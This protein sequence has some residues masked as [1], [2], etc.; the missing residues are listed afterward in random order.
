MRTPAHFHIVQHVAEGQFQVL[1]QCSQIFALQLPAQFFVQAVDRRRR[2]SLRAG[3][4]SAAP[5]KADRLC[6]CN[7][8]GI[9]SARR[10]PPRGRG[11]RR[12]RAKDGGT[13]FC[14][15]RGRGLPPPQTPPS[16]RR[17]GGL[18]PLRR[19]D[20]LSRAR[21][22]RR[23]RYKNAGS[24]ATRRLPSRRGRLLP[25]GNRSPC[26]SAAPQRAAR[27]PQPRPPS[28]AKISNFAKEVN[29][30][31]KNWRLTSSE[32]GKGQ[33][34]PVSS[35]ISMGHRGRWRRAYTK[36][37]PTASPPL[38]AFY[39]RKRNS[40]QGGHIRRQGFQSA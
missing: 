36:G 28:A 11:R 19:A 3:R 16:K 40:R 4:R 35:P 29:S 8:R 12:I 1:I 6:R 33:H 14:R 34:P 39:I 26:R 10:L 22:I 25:P 30:S 20:L 5:R 7:R 21:R 32:K 13:P 24:P 31:C 37:T 15:T 27:L 38:P 2:A 23:R 17:Q 18:R 9:S